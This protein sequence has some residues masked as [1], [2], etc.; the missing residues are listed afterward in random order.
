MSTDN[1]AKTVKPW[2]PGEWVQ[3]PQ[4]GAGPVIAHEYDTGKEMNPKGLRLVCHV[5]SRGKS[6]SQDEANAR[7]IAAAPA[8]YEALEFALRASISGTEVDARRSF[9]LMKSALRKANPAA[10]ELTGHE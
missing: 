7:L 9:D 3:I 6:M 4:H 1:E 10:F 2:T 8:L 5:L